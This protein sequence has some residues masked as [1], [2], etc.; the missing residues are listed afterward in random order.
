MLFLDRCHHFKSSERAMAAYEA[1]SKIMKKEINRIRNSKY[2]DVDYDR[3]DFIV[4]KLFD[5]ISNKETDEMKT[6][7]KKFTNHERVVE[8]FI[9]SRYVLKKQFRQV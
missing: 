4:K 1:G 6:L 8:S 7:I 3:V 5:F 9:E 2:I